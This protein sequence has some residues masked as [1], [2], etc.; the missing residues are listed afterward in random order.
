MG[1]SGPR[2]RMNHRAVALEARSDRGVWKLA[3][4]YPASTG[5]S[6]AARRIPNAVRMPSYAPAGTFEAYTAPAG[7][8]GW[9]VWVRYVAGLPVPDPRPASMT[10]RVCD[11]GSGTEYVGVRIVTVTVAPECPVCGGP[12]GSAVPYRFHEDGDWFV[13]D[14]WKNPCGHV[15]P[16]VTVLAE[17]RKRVAQL[18]EAEQKAAAHAVAIGPAD[19]GE[20]T[21]AVTLLHT[22][23]AEIRGLHA[24]QA[25]QFLD[26]RGHGEAARRVMEEMKARSGHMSARQAALFLADLAAA[27]AACSDCEDGRINYRGADG[28]F[29]SLRCRVCRKETVPSA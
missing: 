13:V 21:E 27:R 11:R 15:D 28:E 9:A 24:K 4:V 26:L 6:S 5:G 10:Y 8:E 2:S 14:K 18:E 29:V 19:A 17:H 16:Y 22:A 12:R 25:A 7:D 23:A 1:T 3:G 20:Y